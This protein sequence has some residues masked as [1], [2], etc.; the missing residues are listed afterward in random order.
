MK[1]R[2]AGF[3]Q[4]LAIGLF[5][6]WGSYWGRYEMGYWMGTLHTQR[7]FITA[8]VEGRVYR[9]PL[10]MDAPGQTVSNC[11]FVNLDPNSCP[12]QATDK[13]EGSNI[14]DCT[15]TLEW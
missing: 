5:L 14:T 9:A 10:I 13:A 12:L 4:G 3:V 8:A 1:Y 2:I 7:A 6:V 11:I 15:F